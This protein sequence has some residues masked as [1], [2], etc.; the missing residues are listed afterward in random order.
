MK[1]SVEW[2]DRYREAAGEPIP[3]RVLEEYA[4]LLPPTGQALDLACGLGGNALFLAAHGLETMAWDFSPVAISRLSRE[5]RRLGLPVTMEVRDVTIHPC[6]PA[7]FDVIVVSRF[8]E[9]K[10][11]TSLTKALKPGGLLYYQTFI[12]ERVDDKGPKDDAFRLGWNE[13]LALFSDLQILVYREEGRIG[14][15]MHGLRN[16]AQ[17]VARKIT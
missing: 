7:C 14:D 1:T 10:L 3:T 11:V 9:R 8:L 13:L 6:K 16:E 15:L 4:H 12:L 17:L 5:V 2:D